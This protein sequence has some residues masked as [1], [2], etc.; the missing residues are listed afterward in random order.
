MARDRQKKKRYY[1]VF[2]V[3]LILAAILAAILISYPM[4][5]V[6]AESAFAGARAEASDAQA[7]VAEP[8]AFTKQVSLNGVDFADRVKIT[9]PAQEL[10]CRIS[11]TLPRD[12][13]GYQSAQVVEEIPKGMN[14]VPKSASVTI[15][16]ERATASDGKLVHNQ[17]TK[18]LKFLFAENYDFASLRGRCVEITLK[19]RVNLSA[20]DYSGPNVMMHAAKFIVNGEYV[21]NMPDESTVSIVPNL[22]VTYEANGAT[23]GD[24]PIDNKRYLAGEKVTVLGNTGETALVKEGYKFGG[25]AK[26]RDLYRS[27]DTFLIAKET[28]LIAIWNKDRLALYDLQNILKNIT[29]SSL[30]SRV[31]GYI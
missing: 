31:L 25:W 15:G 24:A 28:T 5:A 10:T 13:S 20:I 23:S 16:G 26:G 1:I 4:S 8:L 2:F 14:Y 22:R 7:A 6:G 17:T 18:T 27:D 29:N 21:P 11:L 9:D 3:F 12:T 19:A 30:I